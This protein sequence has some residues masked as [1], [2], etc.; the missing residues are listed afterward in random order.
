MSRIVYQSQGMTE[1]IR[2]ME[3]YNREL[4]K[5]IQVEMNW[6]LSEVQKYA[7]K[8]HRWKTRN[9]FAE[10]SVSAEYEMPKSNVHKAEFFLNDKYTTVTTK[11]GERNY[12]V[13]LHE[14][15]YQGY[16]QS[17]IAQPFAHSTSKSGKG[18]KADP[19]LYR[20]IKQK[21]K[22]NASLKKIISK[23]EKKYERV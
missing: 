5:E 4:N 18:W 10:R 7:R 1:L 2:D 14:G 21:W 22:M 15:T 9:G 20:A 23:L 11:K 6:N 12:A 19:F 3:C 13:F 8:N 16:Q 17:P